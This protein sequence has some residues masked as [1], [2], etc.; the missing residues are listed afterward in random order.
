MYSTLESRLNW[1]L[2][3][4]PPTTATTTST[5]HNS[6]DFVSYKCVRIIILWKLCHKHAAVINNR[7]HKFSCEPFR[8]RTF[9]CHTYHPPAKKLDFPFSCSADCTICIHLGLLYWIFLL[10]SLSV[11]PSLPRTF[12]LSRSAA[13]SLYNSRVRFLAHPN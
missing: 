5:A 10:L 1:K 9:H 12:A 13:N 4:C 11:F 7:I 6:N 8:C 3:T 2:P